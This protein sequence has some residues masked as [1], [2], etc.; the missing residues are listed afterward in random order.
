MRLFIYTLYIVLMTAGAYAA[1]YNPNLPT[2]KI[3]E[4]EQQ[5]DHLPVGGYITNINTP[6]YTNATTR[7]IL[8]DFNAMAGGDAVIYGKTDRFLDRKITISD[9]KTCSYKNKKKETKMCVGLASCGSFTCQITVKRGKTKEEYRQILL[10][11]YMHCMGFDDNDDS[12]DLMYRIEHIVSEENIQGYANEAAGRQL[13]W[14]NLLNL[15]S[16]IKQ[17]K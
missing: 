15:N 12:N 9:S 17:I 7:R 10:H 16:S 6:Y 13:I 2:I 5:N 1:M 3:E 8:N 14:K 11:E 4:E